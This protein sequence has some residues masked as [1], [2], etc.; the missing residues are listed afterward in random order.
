MRRAVW[1]WGPILFV[2]WVGWMIATV[3]MLT[4]TALNQEET[5]GYPKW[6]YNAK[7]EGK[8]LADETARGVL[9]GDW[10]ESPEDFK[11][12]IL[13]KQTAQPGPAK[14]Q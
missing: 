11:K 9:E 2:L 5:M 10:R 6:V 4:E 13:P 7:G 12:A 1:I 14:A 8:L 3:V